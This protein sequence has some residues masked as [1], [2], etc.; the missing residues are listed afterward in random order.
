MLSIKKSIFIPFIA[1]IFISGCSTTKKPQFESFFKTQIREDHSKMFNF[2]LVMVS[3]EYSIERN[4]KE[5]IQGKGKGSGNGKGM[6]KGKGKNKQQDK[7]SVNNKEK[8][9]SKTNKI[10][11]KLDERLAIILAQN[12]YCRKGYIELER[13]IGRRYLSIRGE[14]HESASEK[15]RKRFPNINS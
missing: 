15:Y 3:G 7:M 1:L 14:C 5:K 9:Q 13:N 4:S 11:K 12:N 8:K 10:E 2:S 6:G